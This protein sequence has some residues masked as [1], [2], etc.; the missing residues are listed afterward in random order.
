M[1]FIITGLLAALLSRARAELHLKNF[2]GRVGSCRNA[3]SVPRELRQAADI[4]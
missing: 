2:N 1:S 3:E 4:A